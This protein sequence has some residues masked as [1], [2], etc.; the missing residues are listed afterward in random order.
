M[1][2]LQDQVDA[3]RL[4]FSADINR[5]FELKQSFP[6]ASP[7]SEGGY[8]PSPPMDMHSY[9]P[10]LQR[11]NAYDQQAQL[12]YQSLTP[13]ISAGPQESKDGSPHLQQ[14]MGIYS[15]PGSTPMPQE[16]VNWNPT[17]LISQWDSAF[18]IPASA[19]APPSSGNSPPMNM[20]MSSTTP[21]MSQQQAPYTSPYSQSTGMTPMTTPQSMSQASYGP[22]PVFVSPRDWQQSV[23][24][25]FDPE[26]LKRRWDPR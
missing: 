14:P 26:G 17:R 11:D 19:L 22:G 6:Y 7:G 21:T 18:A 15:Q 3:L 10:H 24:S 9:P 23:A 5:P 20:S 12:Q 16:H 2:D 4:A 8:Q 25:A 13:P 1:P